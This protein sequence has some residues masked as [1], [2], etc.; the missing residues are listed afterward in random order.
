MSTNQLLL[1]VVGVV[2]LVLLIFWAISRHNGHRPPFPMFRR[3]E[4]DAWGSDRTWKA[5]DKDND[6]H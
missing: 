1:L 3:D 2:G 5:P 4:D 6:S